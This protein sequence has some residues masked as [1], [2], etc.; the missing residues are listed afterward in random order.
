MAK[1]AIRLGSAYTP[2]APMTAARREEVFGRVIPLPVEFKP[3]PSQALLLAKLFGGGLLFV[4]VFIGIAM[5]VEV[6]G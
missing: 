3:R 4:S 6:M 2:P 5:L 1:P